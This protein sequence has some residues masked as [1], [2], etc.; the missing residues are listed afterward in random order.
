MEL[1]LPV[2]WSLHGVTSPGR[3]DVSRD[4]IAL[5]SR[6][7]AFAFPLGSVAAFTIE[8]A[9]ARRLRGLPALSLRLVGGETVHVASMGGPGSLQDLAAAV[10]VGQSVGSG[11]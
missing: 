9:P 8:R 3:V 7:R 11:T 1:Q 10:G 5:M 6:T 4:R 2:I